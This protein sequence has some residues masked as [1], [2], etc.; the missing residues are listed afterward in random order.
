MLPGAPAAEALESGDTGQWS[1]D[2]AFDRV[3]RRSMLDRV[4]IARQVVLPGLSHISHLGTPLAVEAA[5][6]QRRAV[7]AWADGDP[8]FLPVAVVPIDEADIAIDLIG[9]AAEGGLRLVL[10]TTSGTGV[11][12]PNDPEQIRV[13]HALADSGLVGVLHFGTTGGG[14]SRRWRTLEAGIGDDAADPMDVVLAH[15]GAEAIIARMALSGMFNRT[16]APRLLIAEHGAGWLPGLF[17]SL[18]ACQRAFRAIEPN[19]PQEELLSTQVRRAITV[20]PFVF[21]PVG[22]LIDRI[23]EDVLGFATD[24]PHPEGGRDP[25]GTFAASLGD[26]DGGAFFTNNGTRLLDGGH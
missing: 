26:R 19:I 10:L 12:P 21:E 4:G 24:H 11:T 7:T 18:D 3:E 20:V 8:R 1:F 16:P 15:Q 22:Q 25:V 23:G 6:A 17:T 13:W 14:P 2:A 9:D 5:R